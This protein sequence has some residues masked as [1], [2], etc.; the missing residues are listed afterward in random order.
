M[1]TM[2]TL[3]TA[4][5]ELNLN[6]Y[7]GDGV[8]LIFTFVEDGDPWPTTGTWLAQV[9]SS[10]VN[11]VITS[12]HIANDEAGGVVTASLSGVQVRSLGN[13]AVWDLQQHPPGAEPRTWYR[14]CINVIGDV[15]R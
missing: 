4:P 1:K 3:S 14:G 10:P 11:D 9:R 13:D 2:T 12:F 5:Q 7:S 8:T 15:S 6:L